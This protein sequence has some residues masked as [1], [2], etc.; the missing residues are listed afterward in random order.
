MSMGSDSTN[1]KKRIARFIGN[2]N[3]LDA[4]YWLMQGLSYRDIGEKIGRPHSFVQRV[5]N[6]LRKNGLTTGGLWRI[7][8][9]ALQM[10]KTFKFY[11]Y[12]DDRTEE[13]INNN[14]FLTYFDDIKKGKSDYFALYTFPNE[15][16]KKWVIL[17]HLYIIILLG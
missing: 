9:A 17:F 4:I 1:D 15:I 3:N 8:V 11:E 14:D 10:T 5:N 13:V 6:F 7:D 16:E 12:A 2:Q